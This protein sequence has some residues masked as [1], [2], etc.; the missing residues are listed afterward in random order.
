MEDK[1]ETRDSFRIIFEKR[2][3]D[4]SLASPMAYQRKFHEKGCGAV[5]R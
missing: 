3:C 5:Y 1:M 2:A 4:I